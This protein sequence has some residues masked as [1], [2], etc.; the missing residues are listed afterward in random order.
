MKITI[1]LII[2]I[3]VGILLRSC[4]L[5]NK[6]HITNAEF[7]VSHEQ[8]NIISAKLNIENIVVEIDGNGKI[9]SHN[10][11]STGNVDYYSDYDGKPRSGKIKTI[12]KTLVDYFQDFDG[13]F[14]TEKVKSIG[15]VDFDYYEAADD[16][17][18]EYKL[19]SL[20]GIVLD[21]Y[22]AY[23]GKERDGK[24]KSIGDIKIDYYAGYDGK[25]NEGKI[26]SIEGN[27]K[28]VFVTEIINTNP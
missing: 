26:K 27:T 28:S 4:T 7:K 10:V 6:N 15:T 24:V 2:L 16:K 22:A 1:C 3:F 9:I 25:E 12:G 8:K 14:K 17:H 5:G 13:K 11:G 21:Y 23:D 19:K 20:G 18:K